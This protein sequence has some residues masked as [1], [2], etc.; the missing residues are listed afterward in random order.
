MGSFVDDYLLYLLASASHD[1]SAEFHAEI[2]AAGLSVAEWRVLATLHDRNGLSIGELAAFTLSQQPTLTKLINRM[3]RDG[4]V[5]RIGDD[6]DGRKVRVAVTERG[7]TTATRFVAAARRHED[8]LLGDYTEVEKAQL[9][10]I[11]KRLI[12]RAEPPA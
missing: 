12:R 10:R 1:T 5:K 3:E 9:K 2:K 7:R 6:A 11:L 8:G 4:L